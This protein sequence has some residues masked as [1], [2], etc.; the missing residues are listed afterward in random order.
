MSAQRLFRHYWI[1]QDEAGA[2]MELLRT[3]DELTILCYDTRREHFA[4]CRLLLRSR[5][6]S[7]RLQAHCQALSRAGKSTLAGVFEWGE[8]DGHWYSIA[9]HVNGPTLAQYLGQP[10][11]ISSPQA[12]A[13]C[14]QALAAVEHTVQILPSCQDRPLDRLRV[15]DHS[16][17]L[18]LEVVMA[19]P[20]LDVPQQSRQGSDLTQASRALLAAINRNARLP[21]S[22]LPALLE[23]CLL[24]L[25]EGG[26]AALPALRT[27]LL[28][29]MRAHPPLPRPAPFLQ[30]LLA[31]SSLK[32]PSLRGD[33]PPERW[34]GPEAHQ[35]LQARLQALQTLRASWLPSSLRRLNGQP[36]DG[37]QDWPLADWL[38]ER[39][40]PLNLTQIQQILVA[41]DEA[42]TQA[43]DL[44]LD[45][46]ELRLSH[47]HL[48]W[49]EFPAGKPS[50][51]LNLAP[52]WDCLTCNTDPLL[53]ATASGNTPEP[54]QGP[55][56]VA[57]SQQ[58]D[59]L[60][61]AGAGTTSRRS[62]WLA[63]QQVR[64]TRKSLI[65]NA[66]TT[67]GGNPE[68]PKKALEASQARSP[69]A[70]PP[71]PIGALQPHLGPDDEPEEEGGF[72]ELLFGRAAPAEETPPSPLA[73]PRHPLDEDPEEELGRPP[74]AT[75]LM[76]L[77]GLLKFGLKFVVGSAILGALAAL[78]HSK[79]TAP[80][81]PQAIG[82]Q[83]PVLQ[84]AEDQ[85][86]LPQ[87]QPP[88]AGAAPQAIRP[89]GTQPPLPALPPPGSLRRQLESLDDRPSGEPSR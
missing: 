89:L 36:D 8:D 76:F 18:G 62:L 10:M 15:C 32:D 47:L 37:S 72:A 21:A 88:T 26:M 31:A 43:E 35:R 38:F 9:A 49:P 65:K 66:F 33:C 58:M 3:D 41:L 78:I 81:E 51:R 46:P 83:P 39:E 22:E 77:L 7:G 74:E 27:S 84:V 53:A 40:E 14:L 60:C 70:A 13:L 71:A 75:P 80:P 44:G 28:Q 52:D 2:A 87:A 1:A 67:S 17:A 20:N 23:P 64:Q 50:L 54:H 11:E 85:A 42:L 6:D 5:A 30:H 57:L 86:G 82:H 19:H 4:Q 73:K 56:L 68:P 16:N 79:P 45:L 48:S 69:A 55:W 34:I 63:H 12:A 24:C 25:W 59:A 61:P 29:A